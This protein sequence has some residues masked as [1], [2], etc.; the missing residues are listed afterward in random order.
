MNLLVQTLIHFN[1][2]DLCKM[3]IKEISDIA[4]IAKYSVINPLNVKKYT[5]QYTIDVAKVKN[6]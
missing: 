5:N 2:Q 3:D 1:A 4:V 6:I